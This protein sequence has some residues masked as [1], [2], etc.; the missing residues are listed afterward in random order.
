MDKLNKLRGSNSTEFEESFA[1]DWPALE[2]E[3]VDSGFN[4][5]TVQAEFHT[6]RKWLEEYYPTTIPEDTTTKPE[7]V[8]A[9]LPEYSLGDQNEAVQEKILDLEIANMELTASS[10]ANATSSG[11]DPPPYQYIDLDEEVLDAEFSNC[12][13]K[14]L[15][16]FEDY[17]YSQH[18][19][20]PS[21]GPKPWMWLPPS[22]QE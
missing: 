17:R 19:S 22:L 1:T 16:K 11:A 6:I 21:S 3:L 2:I 15:Q 12:I 4:K 7:G 9:A 5:S 18:L 10:D 14:A 13:Q 20:D 8:D